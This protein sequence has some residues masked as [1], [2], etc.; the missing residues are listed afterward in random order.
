MLEV[1]LRDARALVAGLDVDGLS[2]PDARDL[3]AGFA[4]LER[5]AASGQA[6]GHGPPG[7][8]R[9]RAG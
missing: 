8:D 7:R 9:G 6:P 2:G 3:V 1:L 4:E 5:L